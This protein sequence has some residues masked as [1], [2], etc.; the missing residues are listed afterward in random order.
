MPRSDFF[1]YSKKFIGMTTYRNFKIVVNQSNKN[2]GRKTITSALLKWLAKEVDS[3][4]SLKVETM[5][6]II[7]EE[8]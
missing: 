2:S 4:D 6:N 1:A 3:W 7:S 5:K 8:Q